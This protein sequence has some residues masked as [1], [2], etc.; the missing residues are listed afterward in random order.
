MPFHMLAY[1]AAL[2]A[3][4]ASADIAALA[5]SEFTTRNSHFIFTEPYNLAALYYQAASATAA[6]FNVSSLNALA[7]AQIWPLNASATVPADPVIMD[8]RDMPMPLPENEEVA[9]EGSNSLACMTEQT[10]ALLWIVPPNYN[11]NIPRGL[12][13][14][15]IAAT[16]AVAGVANVWSALGNLTFTE[17]L[18]G[19]WYTLWGAQFFDAGTIAMRFIFARPFLHQG[20]KFRPGVISQEAVANKPLLAQMGG[21]GVLGKFHSFEPPQIEILANATA[22]SAQVIRLG[23]TWHG[24]SEPSIG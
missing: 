1:R 3:G 22:A 2:A 21:F 11:R 16:G 14:M 6:R 24:D 8:M 4:A 15:V 19:G 13:T 7:R 23:I 9:V 12:Q 5:D 18:R 10:T 20:R 17:N